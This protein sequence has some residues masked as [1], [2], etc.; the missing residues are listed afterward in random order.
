MKDKK[1]NP[2]KINAMVPAI[3]EKST[4]LKNSSN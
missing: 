1:V 2:T 3:D 4:R